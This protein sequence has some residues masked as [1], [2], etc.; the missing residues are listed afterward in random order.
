MKRTRKGTQT[1]VNRPVKVILTPADQRALEMIVAAGWATNTSTGIRFAL[2]MASE[3]V[4]AGA[5]A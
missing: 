5:A 1:P 3:R 4:A 2:K